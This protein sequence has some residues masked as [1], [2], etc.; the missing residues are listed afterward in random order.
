MISDLGVKNRKLVLFENMCGNFIFSGMEKFGVFWAVCNNQPTPRCMRKFR[1]FPFIS[2]FR[3]FSGIH[4]KGSIGLTHDQQHTAALLKPNCCSTAK[5]I[6]AHN[7]SHSR[8][9]EEGQGGSGCRNGAAAATAAAAC[10]SSSSAAPQK[11]HVTHTKPVP[12]RCR[13]DFDYAEA[14]VNC[15]FCPRR[16]ACTTPSAPVL[17]IFSFSQGDVARRAAHTNSPA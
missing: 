11:T 16:D 12:Q 10:S 9:R 5:V 17:I 1:R 8:G 15:P 7:G 13:R 6:V 4:G 2:D 14:D 3:D